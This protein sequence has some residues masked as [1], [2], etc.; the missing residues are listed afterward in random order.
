ME[1]L[2]AWIKNNTFTVQG[3]KYFDNAEFVKELQKV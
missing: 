3:Q 2:Q 1:K